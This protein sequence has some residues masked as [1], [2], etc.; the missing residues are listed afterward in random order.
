M[1][2]KCSPPLSSIKTIGPEAAAGRLRG[3]CGRQRSFPGTRSD[4]AGVP[5][6]LRE[7]PWHS[8]FRD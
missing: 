2:L 7:R 3:G 8:A 4:L 6:L 1:N 5:S